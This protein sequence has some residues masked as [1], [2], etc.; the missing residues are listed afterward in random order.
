MTAVTPTP[1]LTLTG[2]DARPLIVHVVYRFQTGGLE[3]GV[4][5]LINRLDA[6]RHVVVALTECDPAFCARIQRDDVD[7]VSLHQ[8]PGHGFRLYP[9][10]WR[11][12]RRLRPA[13]VHTRNLAALESMVPAWLAGVPLRVHGEHGWD[14]DDPRGENVKYRVMRRVYRPFVT[15]YIA[16]SQHLADYLRYKVGVPA[17]HVARICNG[18]DTQ[19]FSPPE[20]GRQALP[21]MPFDGPALTVFGTV[22][23]LQA[24]KDQLNLVRAFALLCEREAASAATL[25]LVIAGEG[26]MRAA[27]EQ[28]AVRFGVADKLWLAGERRDVPAVL[29]A[30]DCFVLPSQA[31]G[32]SNTILE[33]MACGLPVVATDVGGNGELVVPGETGALVPARDAA[34]LAAAMG[35]YA[36]DREMLRQHGEAARARAVAFFSL[37][38]MVANYAAVYHAGAAAG[39]LPALAENG[40]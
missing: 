8:P 14:V 33:A 40:E 5:N 16:L 37:D 38:V 12:F 31:E 26:P 23:R 3:N 1:T 29:R 9:A 4:V 27:L 30:L 6:F 28:E 36:N 10:L 15:R 21:G 39:G 11:L 17:R 35:R 7:Y 13:V 19:R 34:A 18:V 20:G 25:R 2:G 22:G 24:I 32:I